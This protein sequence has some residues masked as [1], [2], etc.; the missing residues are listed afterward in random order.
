MPRILSAA[1][2]GTEAYPADVEDNSG[3]GDKAVVLVT[4]ISPLNTYARRENL[5]GTAPS[6]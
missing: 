1:G 4:S 3:W 6:V 2:N 5:A